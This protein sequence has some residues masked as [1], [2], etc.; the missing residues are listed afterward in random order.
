[1]IVDTDSMGCHFLYG[2]ATVFL[3]STS[4]LQA[5]V[6]MF[7]LQKSSR[8]QWWF[9]LFA[10]ASLHG[11]VLAL[12]TH[13][14][15]AIFVSPTSVARGNGD[16][17]LRV[18]YFSTPGTAET[19][20]AEQSRFSVSV[21]KRKLV[22]RGHPGPMPLKPNLSRDGDLSD[23]STRAGTPFGSLLSGPTE[24]HDVRPAFP[25]VF[26]DPPFSRSELAP[27]IKGDVVVEVTIDALGNVIETRL[28]QSVAHE[29]DEQVLATLQ[30]WR[31]RPATMDGRPIASKHDVYFHFPS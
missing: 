1:M 28:L 14:P 22:Q 21:L 25:V 8:R 10:S 3:K 9:C 26:P 30:S 17:S 12:L 23:H 6:R 31:F 2:V 19:E 27:G 11:M 16:K 4:E 24:G 18:L 15:A 7:T 5:R 29:I 20:A 13:R